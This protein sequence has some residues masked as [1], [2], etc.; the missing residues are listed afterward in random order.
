M[1][2]MNQNYLSWTIE[3]CALDTVTPHYYHA[4]LFHSFGY[5][6]LF[7]CEITSTL[8]TLFMCLL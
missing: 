3:E 5:I 8:F 4:L 7:V 6:A 1:N 2:V